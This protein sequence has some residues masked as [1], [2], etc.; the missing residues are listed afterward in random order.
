[1]FFL[2]L[3]L[4]LCMVVVQYLYINSCCLED[5]WTLSFFL[6]AWSMT[7]NT[8]RPIKINNGRTSTS[9]IMVPAGT[10]HS[11][12]LL[13]SIFLFDFFS[14]KILTVCRNVPIADQNYWFLSNSMPIIALFHLGTTRTLTSLHLLFTDVICSFI[15]LLV[16]VCRGAPFI[17]HFWPFFCLSYVEIVPI[18]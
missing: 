10:S 15:A 7:N 4:L 3:Y 1:L 6:V 2:V 8:R 16:R 17:F 12:K 5:L 18:K 11:E 14:S 13:W 9:S